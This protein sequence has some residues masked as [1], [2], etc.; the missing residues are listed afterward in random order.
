MKFLMAEISCSN[1]QRPSL[2]VKVLLRLS[3]TAK[4][5]KCK[6]IP[7]YVDKGGG[8]GLGISVFVFRH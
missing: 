6:Q 2:D 1:V 5:C 4:E 3:V 7:L 8:R